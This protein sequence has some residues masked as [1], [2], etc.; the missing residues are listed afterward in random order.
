VFDLLPRNFAVAGDYVFKLKI[1]QEDVDLKIPADAPDLSKPEYR[2]IR[3][4]KGFLAACSS[5]RCEERAGKEGTRLYYFPNSQ[6][7]RPEL[8]QWCLRASIAAA[9]RVVGVFGL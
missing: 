2:N 8:V 9:E 6:D 4:F 1:P 5:S 3:D 7:P